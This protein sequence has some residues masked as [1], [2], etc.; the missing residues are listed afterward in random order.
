VQTVSSDVL[1][2]LPFGRGLPHSA[3]ATLAKRSLERRYRPRQ[4]LFRAGEVPTGIHLV[5]EGQVRV[6]REVAGRRQVLH[7][8]DAG[9]TL[10]EVPLFSGGTYP[11]T[12]IAAEPTRC[13][14]L[15]RDVIAAAIAAH[16]ELAFRLLDRLSRRVRELVERL[17]ALRFTPVATRLARQL[18][19]RMRAKGAA[20]IVALPLTQEQ[21]AEEIGTVREVL[22]RELRTL[23]DGGVISSLGG[24]RIRVLDPDRLRQ[25]AGG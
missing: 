20:W 9:G 4:T 1:A 2:A 15:P 5:L 18:A 10:G 16:P 25:L 13:L 14:I 22:V 6:V 21:F 23:R 11:A 17:D 7:V 24:G 19:S 12:A 8:E 3:L